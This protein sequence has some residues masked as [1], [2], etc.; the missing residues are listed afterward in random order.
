M[1][2]YVIV[3]GNRLSGTVRVSGAKNAVLTI[4]PACLLSKGV[5]TIHEVPR[6]SDVF[7]M[8]EVLECLGAHVE[9]T[10]NTMVVN[11]S[12]ISTLEVPEKLT[13]M[14]RASNLVMGPLLS[15]FKQVKLAYPGGCSIGSRP[16]DQHLR[17]MK[18]MG[19]KVTEKYGYIE[20]Q[21][22]KLT[23]SEICLDFPSVGATENLMMAAVLADGVT[24]I[25]NAAREPEIVDLQNFLN[26]M[27]A[28]IRGA[29]TDIIKIQGVQELGSTEH[30]IIPDRIEA[31]TFM[32]AAAIS[33]GDVY[34]ENVIPEHIEAVI[35]K[36]KEAGVGIEEKGDCVRVFYQGP[37][38]G[39]DYKTMPY[40]GFPTDMQAQ[41]M[42]L[43]AISEGTSIVSETIFENR[44]KHVDELRRMG[45]DIHVE[46]RIAIVKGVQ[47][48]TGAHVEASDLRAGAALVIAG[49]A[50]DGA[51][52][53]ENVYHID[54]GYERFEF[55]LRGLG[56]QILRVNGDSKGPH[57]RKEK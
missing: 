48:L 15:R 6:L 38:R 29:G 7:V 32:V 50:A 43:M 54:R 55:K 5:C 1:E 18:I 24:I 27:G 56:A 4:L 2:K 51:T 11:A 26:G 33:R 23:G 36:L 19:A 28:E 47:R 16:M 3:G 53:L 49:L 35:A 52:I 44:F 12:R 30:T 40:P 39:V 34:L 46:S 10:G 41:I 42:A 45:A 37:T 14:M 25:R 8:K 31:G 13:R 9:F 22:T 57:N 21:A 17:G 20:A